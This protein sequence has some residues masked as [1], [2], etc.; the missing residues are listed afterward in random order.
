[1]EDDSFELIPH[2]LEASVTIRSYLDPSPT[3]HRATSRDRQCCSHPH[4]LGVSA[5]IDSQF[6]RSQLY[7]SDREIAAKIDA[8]HKSCVKSCVGSRMPLS[9]AL[10]PSM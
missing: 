10:A 7:Y 8:L 5:H 4:S 6:S 2:A 9:S 3:F 1:M